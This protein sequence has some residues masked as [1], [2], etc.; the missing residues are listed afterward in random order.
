MKFLKQIARIVAGYIAATFVALIA[1]LLL[2]WFAPGPG[3]GEPDFTS[4]DFFALALIYW[5]LI[6]MFAA[7]PALIAV[8][9]AEAIR[10]RSL[11]AHILIGGFIG[12]ILTG[13]AARISPWLNPLDVPMQS[14]VG[15]AVMV[16]AGALGAVVYWAVAGRFAGLWRER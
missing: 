12:F 1:G 9:I 16:A 2:P 11:F 7:I 14:A 4:N 6:A 13:Q 5:L 8:L 15:S 10:L 3:A